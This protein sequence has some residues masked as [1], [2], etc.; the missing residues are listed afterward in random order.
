MNFEK[1]L[2]ASEFC[3]KYSCKTRGG[4]RV[5]DRY[6]FIFLIYNANSGYEDNLDVTND[7]TKSKVYYQV[8]N[9]YND[10]EKLIGHKNLNGVYYSIFLFDSTGKG[11]VF[12]GE[13]ELDEVVLKR[14]E[15]D[16]DYLVLKKVIKESLDNVKVYFVEKMESVPS[17]SKLGDRNDFINGIYSDELI[18][19]D[20]QGKNI[21]EGDYLDSNY[22]RIDLNRIINTERLDVDFKGNIGLIFKMEGKSTPEERRVGQQL[23]FLSEL[24][25]SIQHESRSDFVKMDSLIVDFAFLYTVNVG[26]ALTNFL[27]LKKEEQAE[28]WAIDWGSGASYKNL[29]VK[30]INDCI[31]DIRNDFFDGNRFMISK[32]FISHADSDHYNRIEKTMINNETEVWISGYNFVAGQ[33]LNM[34]N[35]I[36]SRKANFRMPLCC[37]SSGGVNILHPHQPIVYGTKTFTGTGFYLAKNKNNVSPIMK[38]NINDKSCL[39]PGDIMEKGWHWYMIASG[40]TGIKTNILIHS[41]HGSKNGFITNI[42]NV[43]DCEYDTIQYDIDILSTRDN[44]Y[45]KIPSIEI[46]SRTEYNNTYTTQKKHVELKYYKTDVLNNTILEINV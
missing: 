16:M 2:N 15:E 5:S 10:M 35:S 28:V 1:E 44:A 31:N 17:L 37:N 21:E 41:H 42:P 30:N 4:I 12:I 45:Q 24:N 22:N 40:C 8:K 9:K 6:P 46:S 36:K 7:G 3:E 38:I 33:F 11:L 23:F 18:E 39:F 43:S 13:Y 27:V 29:A 14:D 34:L 26:C 20:V 32:L 25:K 19:I